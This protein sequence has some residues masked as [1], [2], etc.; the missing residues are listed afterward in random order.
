MLIMDFKYLFAAIAIV[1][2]IAIFLSL[3][4][5][6]DDF[7]QCVSDSGARMFG[8]YWCSHCENQKNLFGK[9]FDRIEYVECSLPN[10]AGQTQVCRDEQI[11]SYPTWEFGNGERISGELSLSEIA[12]RTGCELE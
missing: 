4:G 1:A 11:I 9:S 8:A 5:E 12:L 7:A 2:V 6:H 10:N 3:P